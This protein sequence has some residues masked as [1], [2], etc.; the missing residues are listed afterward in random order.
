MQGGCRDP[1]MKIG[2]SNTLESEGIEI[3]KTMIQNNATKGGLTKMCLNSFWYKFTESRN[4]PQ[5]ND[6]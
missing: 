6:S 1:R 4:R 5:N 2:T 3:D